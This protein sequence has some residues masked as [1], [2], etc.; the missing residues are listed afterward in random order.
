MTS[1]ISYAS[2]DATYPVAGQ[3]NNSQGFRDNFFYIKAGLETAYNEITVLQNKVVLKSNLTANTPAT[4]DFNGSKIINAETNRLVG[5]VY[6]VNNVATAT[7]ISITNF[8]V[9]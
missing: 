1:A 2:I 7:N 4:N 9:S 5:T 6:A 3:D 8:F